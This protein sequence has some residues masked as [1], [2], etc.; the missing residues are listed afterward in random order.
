MGNQAQKIRELL[1]KGILDFSKLSKSEKK[2]MDWKDRLFGIG[3]QYRRRAAA[4][5]SMMYPHFWC[6][7]TAVR[8]IGLLIQDE[9]EKASKD[10]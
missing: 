8:E 6:E 9:I 5:G 7:D 1:I 10:N 2:A 4:A 3:G